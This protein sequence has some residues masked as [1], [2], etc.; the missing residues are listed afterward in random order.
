MRQLLHDLRI[1]L[2]QL[3]RA[4][5][6]TAVAVFTLGLGLG[7]TGLVLTWAKAVFLEPLPGVQH[8]YELVH[9]SGVLGDRNGLSF[10]GEEFEYIRDHAKSFSGVVAHEFTHLQ[11]GAGEAGG[12]PEVVGAGYVSGDYFDVL[13][14]RPQLGRGFR[15][16]EERVGTPAVAVLSDALWRRRFAADPAVLG[17]LVRLNGV[18][19]TIVGV[20]P[21][22]FGGAYGALLQEL[23]IPLGL[24][25]RVIEAEPPL[26]VMARLRPGVG[27][28]SAAAEVHLLATQLAAE[29]PDGRQGWDVVVLGLLDS[30]RGVLSE[31]VPFVGVLLVVAGLV[32]LIAC[33]NVANLLLVRAVGRRKEVAVRLSLGASRGQL[34]RQLLL[35][36]GCLALAGG[37]VGLGAAWAL[38]QLLLSVLAVFGLPIS[39][40]LGIDARVVLA[41]LGVALLTVLLFALVPALQAGRDD[42]ADTLRGEGAAVVGGFG[43]RRLRAALVV[44]QLALSLAALV[45]TGLLVRTIGRAMAAETGFDREHALVAHFDLTLGGYGEARGRSFLRALVERAQAIPG[46]RAATVTSYVPMG[47]SGGGNG[48]R[49]EI[50]GY[51]PGPKESMAIVTD[52]V[53]PSYLSTLGIQ[54]VAG[55]DFD[56]GDRES[57]PGVVIVNQ[58]MAKRYWPGQNPLGK[59]VKV[60]GAWREV[61]G[62]ERDIVYRQLG[63]DSDPEMLLPVLQ[64]YEPY[65]S[66]VLRTS[67]E[68]RESAS[69]VRAAFA[70]LDPGIAVQSLETLREHT[71]SMVGVQRITAELMG[72][73]GAIALLLT[74]IGLY[75][76]IATG[77]AERRREIGV[78]MALGASF[79]EV[80]AEVVGKG[81]ALTALGLGCGV[82]LALGFSQLLRSMLYG[83]GAGDPV[84]L[85]TTALLLAAVAFLAC[86]I[87]ARRAASLDPLE[88]LRYE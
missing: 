15:R 31:L 23:W 57:A 27:R 82:V 24:R 48:R 53:G 54:V 40:D 68:P 10:R 29:K 26:Q 22:G 59:R 33:A 51:S 35:E 5:G 30:P 50:E 4:P 72:A 81:M 2:R 85:A 62:V 88:A 87:P 43:R 19:A 21:P 79:R 46:V 71:A 49:V 86:L 20:M 70:A 7:A 37:V 83:V 39:L 55:R 9:L 66:L 44:A 38:R 34:V 76:V 69:A 12:P 67:G 16:D 60:A 77:V 36:G 6:F 52:L 42:L 13:G 73:F 8:P 63:E 65:Q 64:V 47:T 84:T 28:G 80:F 74:M 41:T 14:V 78:R 75:G 18:D 32:L 56:A 17:R 61:V 58:A 45:G 1:V 25:G 11:L 3:G